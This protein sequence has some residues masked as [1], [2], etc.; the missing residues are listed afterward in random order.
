MP[1]ETAS[2]MVHV[3]I[4]AMIPVESLEAATKSI[5]GLC[6]LLE[7]RVA[8]YNVKIIDPNSLPII[9]DRTGYETDPP[10]HMDN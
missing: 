8:I 5:N 4:N 7:E 2:L 3:V 9:F 10:K 1:E 6:E